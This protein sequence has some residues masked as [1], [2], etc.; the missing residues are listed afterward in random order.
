[1]KI[2]GGVQTNRNKTVYL[3]IL[4]IVIIETMSEL[5]DYEC[6]DLKK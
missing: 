5:S 3:L 2:E 6:T 4:F 1:M